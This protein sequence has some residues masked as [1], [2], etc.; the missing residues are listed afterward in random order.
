MAMAHGY[1]KIAG[2]PA[3]VMVHVTIST[4]NTVNGMMNAARDNIPV[5]LAA[6][7]TPITETA[8]Y[9]SATDRS[10]GA[11][12]VRPRRYR[13]RIHQMGLRAA[14]GQ[15]VAAVVDR[16]LDI[17]MS[18]PR[19]PVYLTL[20]REVLSDP[21]TA[22]RDH[23]GDHPLGAMAAVPSR[24]AVEQVADL[25]AGAQF[26]LIVTWALGALG[27]RICKIVGTDRGICAAGGAER[28]ERS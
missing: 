15:P 7:R 21:S 9:A 6:G 23:N 2:K 28:A 27:E 26:P 18:E 5:L 20:P 17:A 12:S 22:Q 19:G 3:A 25:I 4:G 14:N 1:Y 11:R 13:A 8:M 24:E 10:I 16:A